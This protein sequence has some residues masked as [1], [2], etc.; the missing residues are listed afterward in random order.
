VL[1]GRGIGR[2]ELTIVHEVKLAL[3]GLVL[4]LPRGRGK[5]RKVQ[6]QVL[7]PI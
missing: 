5:E 7:Q 4:D 3:K 2:S 6:K 1:Y